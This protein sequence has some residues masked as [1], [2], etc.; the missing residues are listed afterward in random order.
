M[1]FH[2]NVS[3]LKRRL[4]IGRSPDSDWFP[5]T[6]FTSSVSLIGRCPGRWWAQVVLVLVLVSSSEIFICTEKQAGEGL[7]GV[8]GGQVAPPGGGTRLLLLQLLSQ[9]SDLLVPSV[10]LQQERLCGLLLGGRGTR[11]Q[12]TRPRG[13][14]GVVRLPVHQL[15][16]LS[17]ELGVLVGQLLQEEG[18]DHMDQSALRGG[19]GWGGGAFSPLEGPDRLWFLHQ[20]VDPSGSSGSSTPPQ[21][22]LGGAA[23]LCQASGTPGQ[24]LRTAGSEVRLAPPTGWMEHLVEQDLC[25]RPAAS[26]QPSWPPG[27]QP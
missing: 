17:G 27:F 18:L 4:L 1:S 16:G 26:P 24:V 23:Q 22:G 6:R 11:P 20:R 19:A 3:A 8:E 9:F 7:E 13:T 5:L 15:A 10:K 2:A 21:R 14:L 25:P 12:G